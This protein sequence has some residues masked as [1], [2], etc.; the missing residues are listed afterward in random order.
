[1][2]VADELADALRDCLELL[3]QQYAE[4]QNQAFANRQVALPWPEIEKSTKALDKYA[5]SLKVL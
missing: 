2:T 1:M 5:A 3:K 4:L